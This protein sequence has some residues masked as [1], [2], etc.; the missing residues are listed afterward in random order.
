MVD[1]LGAGPGLCLVLVALFLVALFL[2]AL[3]PSADVL[4]WLR[5]A[6][7]PFDEPSLPVC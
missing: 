5:C 7:G 6:R 4:V 1:R 2:V 3:F